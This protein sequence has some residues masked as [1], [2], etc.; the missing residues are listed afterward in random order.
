MMHL[1]RVVGRSFGKRLSQD[2]DAGSE[3]KGF[4]FYG[5]FLAP[6]LQ[7]GKS[8]SRR[9]FRHQT[10]RTRQALWRAVLQKKI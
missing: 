10:W 5:S 8:G 9:G 2:G 6:V 7:G 3:G 1:S 4:K